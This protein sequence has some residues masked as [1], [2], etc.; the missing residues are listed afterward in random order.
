[1]FPEFSKANYESLGPNKHFFKGFI[2]RFKIPKKQK[3]FVI[4]FG[5][6]GTTSVSH[7]LQELGYRVAGSYSNIIPNPNIQNLWDYGEKCLNKYDA[8]Q[9]FPWC[10]F[11]KELYE[12]FP[13]GKFIFLTRDSKSWYKSLIRHQGGQIRKRDLTFYNTEDIKS[14]P[15]IVM[16]AYEFHNKNVRSFFDGKLNQPL[17]ILS[18]IHI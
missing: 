16:D 15:K 1:M 14:N 7:A 6:T 10:L 11:Y 13:Q 2:N 8:F 4:S 9:D 5:K 12:R 3:V 18:L 17:Y